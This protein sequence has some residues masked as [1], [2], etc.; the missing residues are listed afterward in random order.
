MINHAGK[1][2]KNLKNFRE[3][4]GRITVEKY[5]ESLSEPSLIDGRIET[6]CGGVAFNH[7]SMSVRPLPFVSFFILLPSSFP[8]ARCL[9]L[10]LSIS[11]SFSSSSSGC[12]SN[13][14]SGQNIQRGLGRARSLVLYF[15]SQYLGRVQINHLTV[16]NIP[17]VVLKSVIQL[18]IP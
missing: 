12:S 14:F 8:I 9:F 18:R 10:S 3:D 16:P 6:I 13:R 5:A 2:Y 1:K 7:L 4:S 15:P 17:Y 11:F